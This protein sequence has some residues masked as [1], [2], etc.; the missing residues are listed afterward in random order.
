MDDRFENSV[1]IVET[2]RMRVVEEDSPLVLRCGKELGP[3]DVAYETYGKLSEKKDNAVLICHAL[4]G[5]AH[6]AGYHKENDRKPGWWEDM[7]GPGKAID[8]NKYFVICSNVLGSCYGTTGPVETN[9]KTGEPYGLDFPIVTIADMVEVQK[10]LLDKLGIKE[11]LAV[12]GG[13]M[14]GM[15]VLQWTVT[16]PEMIKS[17]VVAASTTKL[18]AQAIAFDAVGRHAILAD[19]NFAGGRYHGKDTPDNGLAI[20]RMIGHITYLSE[21]SMRHKFGRELRENSE[22]SYDF[23]SEF[24]VETYLDYQGQRFVERFDANSYLYITKAMDYFDL[25]QEYGTLQKGFA[26]A[27]CRF[28][29]VSFTSDWLFTAQQS[30]EIVNSLAAGGKD[31]SY[32]N[33]YSPYGHDAF[34]LE[35]ITLGAI[36]SGFIGSTYRPLSERTGEPEENETRSALP[37]GVK[38]GDHARRARVDYELISSMIDEGSKVLDVGAGDGELLTRLIADKGVRGEGMELNQDMVVHCINRGLS[39]VHRDIERGLSYLPTDTFDYAILSKTVQTLDNPDKVIREL[40]RVAKKVIVSFPNFGHWR[41]RAGLMFR[42]RAPR[43]KQL[44]FRWY[45]SPNKHF[46]TL[47]D[48]DEFCREQDIQVEKKI[49][50]KLA[51]RRPARFWS[52]ILAQQAVYLTSKYENPAG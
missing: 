5:D 13:S 50:L 28:M 16:Y 35:P 22:Y 19:G 2:K 4:T 8:T 39:V 48:F 41:C 30:E 14:G 31:V 21:E 43:N 6:V 49:P 36:L 32:C 26:N 40:L 37:K 27:N 46:L 25:A 47:K 44:P 9:P 38:P 18:G 34:L 23:D 11:L 1:G 51:S 33:I 29:V 42:G 12:I 3:I 15:Q 45:S 17:A 24:S 10:L 7:V 52:N 20:A